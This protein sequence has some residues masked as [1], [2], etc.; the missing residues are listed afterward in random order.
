MARIPF[1]MAESEAHGETRVVPEGA[2]Q[3]NWVLDSYWLNAAPP[4]QQRT[5][6]NIPPQL[7]EEPA[8]PKRKPR[9][10]A[11]PQQTSQVSYT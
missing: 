1:P 11:K 4:E 9:G 7:I 8:R 5:N 3:D 6:P 10:R 2:P